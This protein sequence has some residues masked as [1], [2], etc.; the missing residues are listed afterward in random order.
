MMK[1]LIALALL[2]ILTGGCASDEGSVDPIVTITN[3]WTDQADA[4]HTFQ[5][6]STDDGETT[7]AFVGSEQ[8]DNV[9]VYSLTGS[10]DRGTVVFTVERP[11]PVRYTARATA[12]NQTRFVFASDAGQLV[13]THD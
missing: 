12:D 2:A 4:T 3:N 1:P 6:N 9:D 7:G 8:F 10:W 13:L 5:F 11:V